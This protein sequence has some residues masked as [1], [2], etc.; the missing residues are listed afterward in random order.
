MAELP[1]Q[2]E[3]LRGRLRDLE[4]ELDRTRA[5]L[6]GGQ[7]EA[8]LGRTREVAGAPV[9]AAR[10]EA[11]NQD[12]LARLGDSLRDRLRSGVILLGAVVNERPALLAIVTPDLVARGLKAGALLGATAGILGGRGGGRPDRAQ[13]G[14]GDPARLDAALAAAADFVRQGLRT[15]D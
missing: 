10:V 15:E 3:G 4:R 5:Q 11:P 6:A 14:G 12:T 1:A 2:V 9:L 7:V 8:L 13:G